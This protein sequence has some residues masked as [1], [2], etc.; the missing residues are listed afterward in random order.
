MKLPL[1]ITFHQMEPSEALDAQI[2]DHADRLDHFYDGI[3]ACRVLVEA[4]HRRHHKGNLYRVRIDL[5]V[6]GKE[7]VVTRDPPEHHA[8]Q[9]PYVSIRDAFDAVRRQL[10]DYARVQRAATKLHEPLPHGRIARIFPEEDYGFVETGDR[11]EIYFHRNAV[12]GESFEKLTP[13][14]EVEF[15]EEAGEK[16]PQASTVHVRRLALPRT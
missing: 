7:L 11:R 12:L 8:H 1:Q 6:P 10:E 15:V 13:G 5:T 14:T 4:S 2:R 16:G 3:I 9:D